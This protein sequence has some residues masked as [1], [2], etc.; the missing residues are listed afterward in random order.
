MSVVN[1]PSQHALRSKPALRRPLP[2]G[3]T[4]PPG[5]TEATVE[6]VPADVQRTSAVA[7]ESFHHNPCH[8][9]EHRHRHRFL[10]AV[11]AGVVEEVGPVG[12]PREDRRGCLC[13]LRSNQLSHLRLLVQLRNDIRAAGPFA[14]HLDERRR[15]KALRRLRAVLAA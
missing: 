1:K 4:V 3:G 2:P 6:R 14:Q 10:E 11:E 15:V 13:H 7:V 9:A 8:S 12:S 5:G